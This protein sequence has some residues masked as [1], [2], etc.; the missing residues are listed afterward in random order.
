MPD[1]SW[2]DKLEWGL[3]WGSRYALAGVVLGAISFLLTEGL[4]F[5]LRPAVLVGWLV[6]IPLACLIG[7]AIVGLMRPIAV[8]GGV[9]GAMLT[10]SVVYAVLGFG[11]TVIFSSLPDASPLQPV[12]VIRMVALMAALGA[13]LGAIAAVYL[14]WIMDEGEDRG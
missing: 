4:D 12:D 6:G 2:R 1:E 9:P 5:L 3:W 7:G 10:G 14:P 11:A 13:F 8:D